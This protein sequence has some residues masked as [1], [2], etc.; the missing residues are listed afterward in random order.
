M[1][2]TMMLYDF[3]LIQKHSGFNMKESFS[4]SVMKN[5]TVLNLEAK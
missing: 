5:I 4:F 3:A 1:I 2:S